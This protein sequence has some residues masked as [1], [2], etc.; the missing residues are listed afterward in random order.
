V[1]K[2][3][4]DIP[5]AA[6]VG[7]GPAGLTA[8]HY[9]SL[10]GYKVTVFEKAGQ[11]GGML[12]LCIPSYRMPRDTLQKEIDS[13]LDEN[14]TLKCNSAFGSD[15]N[16]DSLFKDGYQA[17]FL[18]MGAHK[19]RLLNIEGEGVE[20]V[21][22]AVDFLKAFNLRGEKLAK[23]HVG[24]IGGGDSA[25]DAAR[26]AV[27]QKEVKSVTIIYRRTQQEM[28]SLEEEV[29]AALLEGVKLEPLVSPIRIQSRKDRLYGVECI[30][31]KQGEVDAS[32]R[33]SPVPIP[34]TDHFI[35]FDTL[36]VTIGDVPD[37]DYVFSMGIETTKWGGLKIDNN[38][39][40]ANI[41]GVFA[42]GD[43]VTGPNTVVEAIAAGKKAAVMID[44]Y[45]NGEELEQTPEVRLPRIFIEPPQISDDEAAQQERIAPTTISI[46]ARKRSLDEVELTLSVQAARYEARRCMRC[47]L[48]FTADQEKEEEKNLET[49]EKSA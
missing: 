42:G 48:E 10:K 18:A 23:G 25:V 14:I 11:P 31:N 44:R 36:I 33:R 37:I 3:G 20:G 47:D 34:G 39:L 17:V 16:I 27:R 5:R 30:R 6:V 8:A 22:P 13:L 32:G 7:A 2:T 12:G 29:E 38:T 21:Y 26:V 15:I 19:S 45:L 43:V 35:P 40:A 41:P 9:L 1:V 4:K 46:E 28:P 49:G 24:V